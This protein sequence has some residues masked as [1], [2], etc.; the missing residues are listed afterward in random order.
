[1]NNLEKQFHYEFQI[2]ENEK[3]LHKALANMQEDELIVNGA[4]YLTDERIIFVGYIPNTRTRVTSEVPLEHIKEVRPGKTFLVFNNILRVINIRNE[5]Y[6]F[7]VD[8]QKEW[9]QQIEK[10]IK[11]FV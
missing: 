10:Q 11:M 4:L 3:I 5:E 7:I 8:G 1:V 6:K 2:N 9:L